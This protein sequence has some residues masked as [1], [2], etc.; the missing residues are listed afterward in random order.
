LVV[1][2]AAFGTRCATAQTVTD[3]DD[4]LNGQRYLVRADDLVVADPASTSST[5]TDV[6]YF[7]LDTDDMSITTSDSVAATNL[8]SLSC[9][10]HSSTSV[11]FPQ[12]TQTMRMF[13]LA[14]DVIVTLAPTAGS[15]G[16]DCSNQQSGAMTFYID[17]PLSGKRYTSVV[18]GD[19]RNRWLHTAVGDFDGDGFDDLFISSDEYR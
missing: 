18:S 8:V 12:Q 11:P 10:S 16:T 4:V 19:I 6:D 3:T 9:V 14:N 1:L 15:S 7:A 13:N 17:D 5:S 2:A